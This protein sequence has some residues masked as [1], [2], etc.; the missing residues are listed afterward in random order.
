[1]ECPICLDTYDVVMNQFICEV[2]NKA[3]CLECFAKLKKEEC[4]FCRLN[5]S[6]SLPS[7]Q[8]TL[9]VH[10]HMFQSQS[11]PTYFMTPATSVPSWE[12]SRILTRQLRRERKREEHELQQRRN[13]E[14]SRQHNIERRNNRQPKSRQERRN[15][16]MFDIE[17]DR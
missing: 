17:I 10:N 16:L 9:P 3:F 8:E 2:C 7:I 4:P 15:E 5:F 6:T 13:A 12:H 1:M 14:I 11:L